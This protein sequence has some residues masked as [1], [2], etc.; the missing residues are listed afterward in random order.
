MKLRDLD[1][2]FVANYRVDRDGDSF[3]EQDS[4]DGAQGVMFICPPV[5]QRDD[6]L[7]VL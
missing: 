3:S 4:I 5:P 7:L 1:A 6:S 2:C